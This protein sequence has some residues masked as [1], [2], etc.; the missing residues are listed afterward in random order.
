MTSWDLRECRRG[1]PRGQCFLFAS[2]LVPVRRRQFARACD[3]NFTQ[4]IHHSPAA[5][6]AGSAPSEP[7]PSC[8]QPPRRRAPPFGESSS[9][10]HSSGERAEQLGAEQVWLRVG[11]GAADVG[12][13]VGADSRR[14]GFAQADAVIGTVVA[15]LPAATGEYAQVA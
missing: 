1:H 12:R 14:W 8:S 6:L 13:S 2:C 15:K 9:T 7:R 3:G 5:G 10:T 11:L 4:R